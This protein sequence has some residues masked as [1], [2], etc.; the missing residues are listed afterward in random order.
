MYL[1][2]SKARSFAS[3]A[4]TVASLLFVATAFL[5]CEEE[6]KKAP[7]EKVVRTYKGD[8]EV[9]NSCGMQGAARRSPAR[10]RRRMYSW[11]TAAEPS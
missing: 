10:S 8:V 2:F 6:Q 11:S 3:A 7:V 1:H 4:A 5:G 9:L